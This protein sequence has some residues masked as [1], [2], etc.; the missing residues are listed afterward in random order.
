LFHIHGSTIVSIAGLTVVGENSL[1]G[2]VEGEVS[3]D[4]KAVD[5]GLRFT[6]LANIQ[7]CFNHAY[8]MKEL[9]PL[10]NINSS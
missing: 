2:R 5:M 4:Q 10:G 8:K 3:Q 6:T 9:E 1:A 7:Q